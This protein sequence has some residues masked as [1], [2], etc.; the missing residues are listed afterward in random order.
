MKSFLFLIGLLCAANSSLGF[1]LLKKDKENV[2]CTE[3]KDTIDPDILL[4]VPCVLIRLVEHLKKCPTDS[5]INLFLEGI[6][7]SEKCTSGH[8]K[9]KLTRM[10]ER[11]T[12]NI[13]ESVELKK[14][15]AIKKAKKLINYLETTPSNLTL[16]LDTFDCPTFG[17]A[18]KDFFEK[19]EDLYS[20][21][22]NL[23]GDKTSDFSM[24]I[25]EDTL[26]N[27]M[28]YFRCKKEIKT[29]E[30]FFHYLKY[31][32]KSLRGLADSSNEAQKL[33]INDLTEIFYPYIEMRDKFNRILLSHSYLGYLLNSYDSVF[34]IQEQCP[35]IAGPTKAPKK[36]FKL[37]GRTKKNKE[38]DEEE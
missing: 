18:L 20:I 33:S 17:Y 7:C 30:S 22:K 2:R 27:T 35:E 32:L 10:K 3:L 13:E 37:F 16:K 29:D 26:K 1:S 15:A 38:Q 5:Y 19:N 11:I 14:K 21:R 36:K 4:H 25:E 28:E 31:L 24:P 23:I 6:K 12:S 8:I 34:N 9:N